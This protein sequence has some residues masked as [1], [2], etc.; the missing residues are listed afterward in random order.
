M[1][2]SVVTYGMHVV[3]DVNEII[4]KSQAILDPL[5]G[6]EMHLILQLMTDNTDRQMDRQSEGYLVVV[7]KTLIIR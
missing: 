6:V 5:K 3:L 4:D 7:V 1:T 2:M